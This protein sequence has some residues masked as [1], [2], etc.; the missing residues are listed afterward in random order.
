MLYNKFIEFTTS[1]GLTADSKEIAE[2]EK[3]IKRSLHSNIIYQLLGMR[4]HV[5]YR[6]LS[7]STVL[8][9]V[10]VLEKGEAFPK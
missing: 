8:K 5:R 3:L 9:A 6:N 2:S 10:E 1:K 4:E 7:D